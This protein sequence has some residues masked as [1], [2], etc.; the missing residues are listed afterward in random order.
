MVRQA[1][2]RIQHDTMPE[3]GG[4]LCAYA[5]PDR[6]DSFARPIVSLV[7]DAAHYAASVAAIKASP[8]RTWAQAADA[9]AAFVS[10]VAA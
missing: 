5:D 8:L 7:G 4:D 1:M 2:R 3:V 10:R 6:I 9:I